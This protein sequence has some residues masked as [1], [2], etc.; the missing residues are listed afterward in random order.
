MA[1]LEQENIQIPNKNKDTHYLIYRDKEFPFSLDYFKWF[2]KYFSIN[3]SNFKNCKYI[4]FDDEFLEGCTMFSDEIIELFIKYIKQRSVSISSDNAAVLNYFSYKFRVKSLKQSTEKYL[5]KFFDIEEPKILFTN[6]KNEMEYQGMEELKEVNDNFLRFQSQFLLNCQLCK[7]SYENFEE[8][9]SVSNQILR[10]AELLKF[11]QMS[12]KDQLYKFDHYDPEMQFYIFKQ[13]DKETQLFIFQQLEI[14]NQVSIIN[15]IHSKVKLFLFNQF[16]Q[17]QQITIFKLLERQVQICIFGKLDGDKQLFLFDQFD[18]EEKYSFFIEIQHKDQINLFKKLN[19]EIQI[20]IFKKLG[21]QKQLFILYYLEIDHQVAIFDQLDKKMQFSVFKEIPKENQAL[22]LNKINSDSIF[23][24]FDK[25]KDPDQLRLFNELNG[26]NQNLVSKAIRFAIKIAKN[27]MIGLLNFL[28]EQ[29]SKSRSEKC[30]IKYL[31]VECITKNLKKKANG[32][33]INDYHHY[34]NLSISYQMSQI[35]YETKTFHSDEMKA[36]LKFYVS[37]KFEIKYPSKDFDAIYDQIIKLKPFCETLL[38]SIFITGIEDT[39]GKFFKNKFITHVKLDKTTKRIIGSK[40]KGSFE[41]C[42]SLKQIEI[43]DSVEVIGK[44]AFSGCELLE[45]L[46]LPN[47]LRVID[48]SAF[49]RC[50]SIVDITIPMSVTFIGIQLLAGCSSLEHVYMPESLYVS[51]IDLG[52]KPHVK[53][54]KKKKETPR[55]AKLKE[56]YY[57]MKLSY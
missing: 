37:F 36:Y 23:Y 35:L 53:V 30:D 56:L 4:Q 21:I 34:F 1:M 13:L 16:N 20:F 44:F 52:I 48:Y 46:N 47:S 6:L 5:M 43:P 18:Q 41:E 32:I 54:T 31:T 12:Q 38:I 22:L 26:E 33:V 15:R 39:D 49:S 24:I 19:D 57:Q 27:K 3:Y 14:A 55:L 17:Q 7:N 11:N 9:T 29:Y 51:H 2:A 45:E 28:S 8:I 50:E 25:L 40:G 10:K 42:S